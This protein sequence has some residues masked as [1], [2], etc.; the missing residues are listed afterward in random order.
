VLP[1]L[2]VNDHYLGKLALLGFI[3]FAVV[4]ITAI[5]LTIWTIVNRDARVV[6]VSQPEFLVMIATGVL[7]MASAIIPISFD[8][9][10][11][12]YME[13]HSSTAI[14]MSVPWLIFLGFSITISALG[15]KT[16]RVNRLFR[17][18]G[19]FERA[20]VTARD[21]LLPC[22][23]LISLNIVILLTWTLIDPIYYVR[24]DDKGTD[25]WNRVTGTYGTCVAD[26]PLPYILPL[27]ILNLSTLILANYEAYR[28]RNIQGEFAESKYIGYCML[29]MLQ[30]A[31]LG[32]PILAMVKE[33]PEVWYFTLCAMLFV[34]CMVI[35]CV[36]FVPK[37]QVANEFRRMSC[38]T[39]Q[40]VIRG[41][42]Q[43]TQEAIENE[44]KAPVGHRNTI[45]SN[46]SHLK[47]RSVSRETETYPSHCESMPQQSYSSAAG[48]RSEGISHMTSSKSEEHSQS[49]NIEGAVSTNSPKVEAVNEEICTTHCESSMPQQLY[50]SEK[51]VVDGSSGVIEN[52][53]ISRLTSLKSS[54]GHF[55][56]H[57]VE[58]AAPINS[59]R[60]ESV[61][62]EL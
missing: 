28:A 57:E 16:W 18:N 11:K 5:G 49:A 38:R 1:E 61:N 50:S 7:V 55:Q 25:A 51:V 45:A 40:Q 41:Y 39:Q 53:G 23:L 46:I 62:D 14:C 44:K 32:A 21:V 52:K 19:R 27:V 12:S 24:T 2:V 37:V 36:I 56:S 47:S 15:A 42:I 9:S 3:L 22:I 59:P 26:N 13:G 10:A 8:D 33:F 4:A 31:L 58:E 29:A 48:I 6:K 34:I 17:S 54:D 35:L 43:Q 60:T 20:Q 30:T